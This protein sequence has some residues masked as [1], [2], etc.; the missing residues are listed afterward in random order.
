[1]VLLC[2][3]HRI[4]IELCCS[5][6]RLSGDVCLKKCCK[7]SWF[8]MFV[9][10]ISRALRS[11]A[12]DTCLLYASV[13]WRDLAFHGILF[14]FSTLCVHLPWNVHRRTLLGT[15]PPR[16]L[17]L[18]SQARCI[19]EWISLWKLGAKPSCWELVVVVQLPSLVRLCSPVDCSM[20]GLPVPDQLLE[21]VQV[22][23]HCICDAVQ[24]S[25]PLM[26]SSPSALD[27]SQH[28]GLFQWVVC[29]H[30]MNK[31]LELQLQH[32][33]FQWIFRDYLS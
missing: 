13:S 5:R 20:P 8:G 18:K 23:V 10:N 29:S 31:I 4:S 28:W 27:L 16:C 14:L 2:G 15:F 22:Q 21:F 24:P 7:L 9:M 6:Q 26:P 32:Q 33:S 3:S 1:M 25:H 12:R 11:L 30:Q 17:Q 19:Q